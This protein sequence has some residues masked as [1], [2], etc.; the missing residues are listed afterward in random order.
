MESPIHNIDF[1]RFVRWGQAVTVDQAKR[2]MR[3]LPEAREEKL[4]EF[5]LEQAP[6]QEQLETRITSF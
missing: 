4:V 1:G 5:D 2:L 6:T 3:F